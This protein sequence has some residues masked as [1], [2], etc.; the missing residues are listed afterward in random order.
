MSAATDNAQVRRTLHTLTLLFGREV[1]GLRPSEIAKGIGESPSVVSRLMAVLED[2][3][4]A[5][6]VPG[7][8]DAW[9]LGPKL[10]QGALAH[11][12]GLAEIQRQLDETTHRFSR[13]P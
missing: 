4:Y 8:E 6:R 9:R 13:T 7:R 1:M 10:V 3:G 5:E 2:E 12:R 11:Q